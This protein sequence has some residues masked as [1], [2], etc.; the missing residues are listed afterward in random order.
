MM[1][2]NARMYAVAPLAD[3]LWRRLLGVIVERSQ[4]R[5]TFV[6][7]P[8]PAPIRELWGRP[9]K[10]AVFMCGLPYSL[11]EPRPALIAAPVPAVTE[12][13]GQAQ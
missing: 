5:I 8:P 3:V 1:I 2:A 9:D 12:S 7:H 6:E 13:A 4:L 11:S 10:A